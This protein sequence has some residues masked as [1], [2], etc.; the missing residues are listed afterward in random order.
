M[1][2]L[3][4]YQP[5]ATLIVEGFKPREFRIWPA[6]QTMVGQRIVI[7]AAK[8]PM[9]AAELR[10]ILTY[11]TS[12]DG[13]RDGIDPRAHDLLEKVWRREVDLPMSAGIGTAT[14][15]SSRKVDR[16]G[17]DGEPMFAWPMIDVEKWGAP[18]P[19]NGARRFWEWPSS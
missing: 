8:R 7:H 10:D 16:A 9:R 17:D 6:P 1:K 19:A 5:W 18:Q 3:T 14:L 11:V 4:V 15:G 12:T 2:A 13:T